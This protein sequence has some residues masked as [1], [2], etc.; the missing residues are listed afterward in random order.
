MLNCLLEHHLADAERKSWEPE[1]IFA[2]SIYFKRNGEWFSRTFREQTND[3]PR[4]ITREKA[5]AIAGKTGRVFKETMH[6][7][8]IQ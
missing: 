3:Y 8:R 7:E 4:G 2:Y 6:R 5:K 1:D